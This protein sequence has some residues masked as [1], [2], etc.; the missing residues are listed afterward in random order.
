V[1]RLV[2]DDAGHGGAAVH[3]HRVLE[4]RVDRAGHVAHVVPADLARG[5]GEPVGEHVRGG[6]EQEPRALDRVAGDG[7]DAG[8]LALLGAARIGI[9][10]AGDLAAVVMLDAQDMGIRPHLEL[11]GRL[12]LRD[13][14]IERR[15]FRAPLA[16]LEAEAGLLAGRAAVAFGRVDRH[17]AGVAVRVAERVGAGLQHLEVVVARQGRDAVGVGHPHP[18]LGL[19]VVGFQIGQRQRPVEQVRARHRAVGG[20]RLELVL[21]EAQRGAGPVDGR[22]AHRLHDPGRQVRE[23]ARD[24]P[25][26]RGG[27]GVEPADLD[28]AAPFVVLE[29]LDLVPAAGLE[30]HGVD[31]LEG[32]LGAERAAA[33]ARTDDDDDRVVV[34]CIWRCH[35]VSPQDVVRTGASRLRAIRC[36]RSRGRCSRPANRTRP[37]SRRAARPPAGCRG[38]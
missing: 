16:A 30:D 19:R 38:R 4:D 14:G 21:L 37:R 17:V 18:V 10:H 28:E 13:L 27:A 32:E 11:A 25:L 7:D 1:A 5:I 6:V 23:V 15:P 29:V 24:A 2:L 12:A 36:R 31:A 22:A 9:D 20:Q 3:V 34:L 33:G 26:A 8:G 35:L